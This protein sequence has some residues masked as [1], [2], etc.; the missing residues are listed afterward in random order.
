LT[1]INFFGFLLQEAW[2]T[3]KLKAFIIH[4]EVNA[5]STDGNDLAVAANDKCSSI[6]AATAPLKM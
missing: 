4:I 5:I 1:H 6:S 2:R 3:F